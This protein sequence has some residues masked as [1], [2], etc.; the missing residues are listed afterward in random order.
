MAATVKAITALGA[1]FAMA[2]ATTSPLDIA[3]RL[4]PWS[5]SSPGRALV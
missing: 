4:R 3:P 5:W 1:M 2:W